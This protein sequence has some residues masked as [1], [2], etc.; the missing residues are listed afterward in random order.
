MHLAILFKLSFYVV[1]YIANNT[2]QRQ[3]FKHYDVKKAY[4]KLSNN[5]PYGPTIANVALIIEIC[6]CNDM[7]IARRF[8]EKPHCVDFRVFDGQL[9]S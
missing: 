7:E 5:A 1:S 4:Y 3:Q 6:L 2:T 8:A 9:A